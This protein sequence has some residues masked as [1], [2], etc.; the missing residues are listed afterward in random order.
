MYSI[1]AN[2]IFTNVALTKTMTSGGRH[3]EPPE[4]LTDWRARVEQDLGTPAAH[5]NSRF[6][7]PARQDRRSPLS[8]KTPRAYRSTRSSSVVAVRTRAAHLPIARLGPRRVPR[9][10]VS[11]ETTA[12]AVGQ[13]GNLRRDPFAMLPSAGTTWRTTSPTG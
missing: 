6:T 10:I 5:P 12:A 4:G 13:V 8:G 1:E 7:A 3:G 11:S 9:L 2:T